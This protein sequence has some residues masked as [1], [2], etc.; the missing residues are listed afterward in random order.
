MFVKFQVPERAS[1]AIHR[2]KPYQQARVLKNIEDK[3]RLLF[4]E[5]SH[6]LY[7]DIHNYISFDDFFLS[8]LVIKK[9]VDEFSFFFDE[10]LLSDDII[11]NIEIEDNLFNGSIKTKNM[12]QDDYIERTEMLKFNILYDLEKYFLADFWIEF[13]RFSQVNHL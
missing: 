7:S 9:N 4:I 13:K 11:K 6:N 3:I 8:F 2:L 12:K 10:E 5:N 1:A